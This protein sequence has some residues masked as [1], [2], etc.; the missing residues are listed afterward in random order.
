MPIIT[1]MVIS[2]V[3]SVATFLVS[4]LIRPKP[5]LENARP[6]DSGDFRVTTATEG[7][8]VPLIWGTVL[9]DGP[10]IVWWG[11]I[12]TDRIREKIKTGMFSSTKITVG[13]RYFVSFQFALCRGVIDGVRKIRYGKKLILYDSTLTTADI[14]FE[15]D[16]A[17]GGEKEPGGNGGMAGRFVI[18]P[19]DQVA[20]DPHL[21]SV[22]G[23][24]EL[25]TYAGTAYILWKHL[26][27]ANQRGG[28]L[29]N[30]P[31][32]KMFDF[33]ISRFPNNLGLTGSN[34]IVNSLDANPAE[35]IYEILTDPDW[36]L[37]LQAADV[38]LTNFAAVGETLFTE[39]N[40]FSFRLDTTKEPLEIIREV[41]RQI[42]GKLFV[43]LFTAKFNLK[44]IRNDYTLGA[45]TLFDESNIVEMKSFAR[46]AWNGTIN[47]VRI[48][49]DDATK[50]YKPTSALAQDGANFE[51]QGERKITSIRFPG[52]KDRTLAGAIAWRELRTLSYPLAQVSFIANRTAFDLTPA[53]VIRLSWEEYDNIVDMPIRITRV[54][55]GTLADGRIKV[56]GVQ[57]IFQV[58]AS[59]FTPAPDS[60]FFT[61]IQEIT[62]F[63]ASDQFIAELPLLFAK[64]A[65][66]GDTLVWHALVAAADAGGFPYKYQMLW[67]SNPTPTHASLG[68]SSDGVARVGTLRAA[69]VGFT[70]AMPAQEAGSFFVDARTGEDLQGLA[71][72]VL[73]LDNIN[74][75]FLGVAIIDPG[76]VDEEYIIYQ[77]CQVDG[78]TGDI[79]L[80]QVVRGALDTSPKAH[81]SNAPIWFC[82]EGGF[83]IL[84]KEFAA[85]NNISVVLLGASPTDA[86]TEAEQEAV[87]D[88]D[89]VFPAANLYRAAKPYV[90]NELQINS[91]VR[92]A[93][94]DG[95][96]DISEGSEPVTPGLS[97]VWVR[98]DLNSDKVLE[99]ANG[100]SD[101]GLTDW[102]NLNGVNAD[103]RWNVWIYDLET[104]PSPTG[105]G[106]A[107]LALTTDIGALITGL[108]VTRAEIIAA[109][110]GNIF[111][112]SMR[113]EIESEHDTPAADNP[114]F[115]VLEYDFTPTSELQT[116]LAMGAVPY[117]TLRPAGTIDIN[118]S[119]ISGDIDI[120]F[121]RSMDHQGDTHTGADFEVERDGAVTEL[122][123]LGPGVGLRPVSGAFNTFN[124]T[125][126]SQLQ[127][128]HE[129]GRGEA[130][131]FKVVD[132]ANNVIAF[133]TLA[134]QA[135][136]LGSIGKPNENAHDFGWIE[137]DPT[138]VMSTALLTLPSNNWTVPR[139]FNARIHAPGIS[140]SQT[141]AQTTSETPGVELG[142]YMRVDRAAGG[143]QVFKMPLWFEGP[144]VEVLLPATD[145]V[146]PAVIIDSL[147][148]GDLVSFMANVSRAAGTGASNPIDL[149][150]EDDD[151]NE[152]LASGRFSIGSQMEYS[153]FSTSTND[154]LANVGTTGPPTTGGHGTALSIST[155]QRLDQRFIFR[156]LTLI[157][158]AGRELW[159]YL[160]SGWVEL[161]AM[162]QAVANIALR[163]S[164]TDLIRIWHNW[165]DGRPE[166]TTAGMDG[167]VD[168]SIYDWAIEPS[169]TGNGDRAKLLEVPLIRSDGSADFVRDGNQGSFSTDTPGANSSDSIEL[170]SGEFFNC[171]KT[172]GTLLPGSPTEMSFGIWFKHLG[173]PSTD[174]IFGC[175]D[176]AS[177]NEGFGFDM[178]DVDEVRAWI[179]D[180]TASEVSNSGLIRRTLTPSNW[181]HLVYTCDLAN[182]RATLYINGSQAGAQITDFTA[183]SNITGLT[184]LIQL[185]RIGNVNGAFS[186]RYD[187]AFIYDIE[188]T[189]GNVT[190]IYNAGNPLDLTGTGTP[191][192]LVAYWQIEQTPDS[193]DLLTDSA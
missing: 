101:A 165:S 92:P 174:P 10:N 32:F 38:D 179:G 67:G 95:D 20:V 7:R 82:G 91:A 5:E 41:E 94:P 102:S 166:N 66:S 184:S 68:D 154:V 34:H 159:A 49:F 176:N 183:I 143:F 162:P 126:I 119:G 100:R 190:T 45:L 51:I 137:Y 107:V 140:H 113:V 117:D 26:D 124:V 172:L 148:E 57:D 13:F 33:Q 125:G 97:F 74:S 80:K 155:G 193:L 28:Y 6:A 175:A 186:G 53:S 31:N 158:G 79:E 134:A 116:A 99:N 23:S 163:N 147:K 185:A 16:L 35:V 3:M 161:T 64:Q 61:P 169:G 96:T 4:E 123:T 48:P 83:E 187:E 86:V 55:F 152:V 127:L 150:I 54:D 118:V 111:P 144:T 60:E 131:D 8:K 156:I 11:N 136:Q 58:E 18:H 27:A 93:S 69:L 128:K 65:P 122:P 139:D 63:T 132:D 138:V 115:Q 75:S 22:I 1:M 129:H 30:G 36:G 192:G 87:A 17:F 89:I 88:L 180:W 12:S 151:T 120:I 24:S 157:S 109:T 112:N 81:L 104:T 40:G 106:Q 103:L 110:T 71:I 2:L 145:I 56:D 9:M 177:W 153:S 76:T 70:S 171:G 85:T 42:A 114:S 149:Y 130:I 39:G 105:R 62:P 135:T 52:I 191:A 188:L 146:F 167:K 181:N 160:N 182:D 73:P 29:G 37:G 133:G 170:D 108:R 47:E 50:D 44:L 173:T 98:R 46:T 19:G 72:G 142:I 43:D 14:T 25:P 168:L 121:Q 141:D 164:D 90:P 15:D 21:E 178:V 189:S 78:T 77:E 84:P 59:V